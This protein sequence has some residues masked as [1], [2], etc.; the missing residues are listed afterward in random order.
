[1]EQLDELV[2]RCDGL[3]GE[4]DKGRGRPRALSFFTA[5]MVTVAVL[6]KNLAQAVAGDFLNASQ[7]TI[8]RTFR[9]FRPV[10]AAVLTE[11]VPD[12]ATACAGEVPLVDGTLVSTG[13]RAG[14][15]ELHSGK[16]HRAGVNVQVLA[17]TRRRLV[18]LFAP[19]PGKTHDA[20]AL[21]RTDLDKHADLADVIGDLGYLGTGITTGVRKPPGRDLTE[22]ER[23]LNK[24]IAKIRVPV[25]HVI[26]QVKQWQVLATGYRG[27]LDELPDV[28][29]AV[30][31][32]EFFR[33]KF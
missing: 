25:E 20:E 15:P 12:V 18:A 13:N 33:N 9:Y 2:A 7:S 26:A 28:I 6:R 1:M 31:A 4:W 22:A 8:S 24:D 19:Q 23:K 32:L 21:R 29:A 14:Q 3:L 30:V 5:I 27:R 11:F 17:T 16:R 10:V